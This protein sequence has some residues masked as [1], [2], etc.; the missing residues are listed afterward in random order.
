MGK[1]VGLA[2]GI[3]GLV[4]LLSLLFA[5]PVQLLWNW[6]MPILFELPEITLLQAWGFNVLCGFLFRSSSSD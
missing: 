1:I 2:V 6:L 3:L 4:V 5:W